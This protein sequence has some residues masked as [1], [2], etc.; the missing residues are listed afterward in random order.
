MT[1]AFDIAYALGTA[2][3]APYWMLRPAARR[4]LVEA[5]ARSRRKPPVREGPAVMIHAVSLGEINAIRALVR[6]L[7]QARPDV[8]FIISTTTDTGYERGLQL[9]G[10]A[11]GTDLIRYPMDLSAAI[12]PVLDRLKPSVVVLM[13]LEVWPNFMRH[14]R[15]RGSRWCW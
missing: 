3:A 7:R 14:C 9:Y 1:N 15:S 6:M 5:V 4:K 13:E 12:E 11:E 8:R 10:K 2:L